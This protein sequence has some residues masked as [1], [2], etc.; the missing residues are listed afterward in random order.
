MYKGSSITDIADDDNEYLCEPLHK[1]CRIAARVTVNVSKDN[2]R[3]MLKYRHL[4]GFKM[5]V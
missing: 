5:I 1:C 2:E 3:V 4:I